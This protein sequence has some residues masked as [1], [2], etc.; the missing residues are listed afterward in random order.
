MRL[1]TGCTNDNHRFVSHRIQLL[2]LFLALQSFGMEG[3]PFQI[4]FVDDRPRDWCPSHPC[5][6]C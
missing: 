5:S 1:Q 4:V 6:A 2:P 3:S